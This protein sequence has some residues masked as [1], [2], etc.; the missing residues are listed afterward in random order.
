M[1]PNHELPLKD[2]I[3]QL[4]KAGSIWFRNSDLLL[5]EEL[6]RRSHQLQRM[7]EE[8]RSQNAKPNETP[9]VGVHETFVDR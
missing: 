1:I 8:Q 7:F 2:L 3:E 5:L 9:V 4:R 6:I